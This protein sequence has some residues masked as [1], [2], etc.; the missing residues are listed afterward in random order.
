M[1]RVADVPPQKIDTGL[2]RLWRSGQ[3]ISFLL[4]RHLIITLPDSTR[5][6]PLTDHAKTPLLR[7]LFTAVC[8]P[9]VRRMRAWLYNPLEGALPPSTD[10]ADVSS[11]HGSAATAAYGSGA[12]D[13]IA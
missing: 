8:K 10:T 5:P 4:F 9:Y 1:T 11:L 2:P 3:S 13:A 12:A 7:L 6:H